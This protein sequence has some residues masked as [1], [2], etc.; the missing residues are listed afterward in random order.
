[1]SILQAETILKY[2]NSS[3][4]KYRLVEFDGDFYEPL[5][6]T[7]KTDKKFLECKPPKP[8]TKSAKYF[9]R[10]LSAGN[11]NSITGK[12][13]FK[14]ISG[15]KNFVGKSIADDL[16]VGL[17]NALLVDVESEIKITIYVF[18]GK[19]AIKDKLYKA[20]TS[21]AEI[22]LKKAG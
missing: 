15:I 14:R 13:Y 9:K 20:W 10:I 7:S 21:G 12:E 8:D 16:G 2:E 5:C 22:V 19:A 1:M 6:P 17:D 18:K 3:Y 11:I 4:G